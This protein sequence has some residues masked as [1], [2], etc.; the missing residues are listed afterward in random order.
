MYNTLIRLLSRNKEQK[1]FLR[2][3]KKGFIY[4]QKKTYIRI[5]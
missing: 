1:N 4:R 2:S 3:Y 5:K